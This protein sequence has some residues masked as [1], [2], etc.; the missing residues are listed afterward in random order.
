MAVELVPEVEVLWQQSR[1]MEESAQ[2]I[3]M[4]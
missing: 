2:W 4:V 3:D 1:G